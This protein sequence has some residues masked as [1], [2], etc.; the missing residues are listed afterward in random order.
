MMTRRPRRSSQE[1]HSL[2][3]K[4]RAEA[5]QMLADCPRA[6]ARVTRLI[7][8]LGQI[9]DTWHEGGV[10]PKPKRTSSRGATIT[11]YS[12]EDWQAEPHLVEKRDSGAQP[13]RTPKDHYD[14]VVDILATANEPMRFEE[15]RV[16]AAKQL[17]FESDD[18]LPIYRLRI[19]MRFLDR[20]GLLKHESRQYR[21]SSSARSFTSAASKE[22]KSAARVS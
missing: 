5:A 20:L 12:V 7:Q 14:A 22:W 3:T 16:L 15:I 18:E 2:L 19:V 21:R 9:E 11:G 17:G 6:Q 13:F 10:A 8:L 4:A 1:V